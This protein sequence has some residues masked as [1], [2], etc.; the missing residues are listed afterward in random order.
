MQIEFNFVDGA[1]IL[2]K[3]C[4]RLKDNVVNHHSPLPL[5]DI[6]CGSVTDFL[7]LFGK[8]S[9]KKILYVVSILRNRPK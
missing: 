1:I 5:T 6:D 8:V 2:N 9:L 4:L 7:F 3:L